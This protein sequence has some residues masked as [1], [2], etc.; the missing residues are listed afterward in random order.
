MSK[1]IQTRLG[2]T[3][4]AARALLFALS[5]TLLSPHFTDAQTG[6]KA[7]EPSSTVAQDPHIT[8]RGV[9]LSTV[10]RTP[11]PGATVSLFPGGKKVLTDLQGRF[12]L[13]GVEPSEGATV[14]VK[15][16]GY[17]CSPMLQTSPAPVCYKNYEPQTGAMTLTLLPEAAIAGQV[18]TESGYPIE[19]INVFISVK[20]VKDGRY[21]W[22]P[23]DVVPGKTDSA[24]MFRIGNLEP[25]TYLVRTPASAIV[26]VPMGQNVGFEATWY[27]RASTQQDAEPIVLDAGKEVI[28]NLVVKQSLVLINIPFTWNR[29]GEVGTAEYGLSVKDGDSVSAGP[30]VITLFEKGHLFQAYVPYGHYTFSACLYPKGSVT[31]AAIGPGAGVPQGASHPQ[32]CGYEDFTVTEK[33]ISAPTLVLQQPISVPLRVQADLTRQQQRQGNKMIPNPLVAF[34]LSGGGNRFGKRVVWR[35]GT[36]DADMAFEGVGPGEYKLDMEGQQAYV[37]SAACGN[38]D[39]LHDSLIVGGGT[40]V[41]SIGVLLRNDFANV[42]VTLSPESRAKMAGAGLQR[43]GIFLVPLDY[44]SDRAAITSMGVNQQ[45]WKVQLKPG[46]YLAFASGQR[47]IAWYEPEVQR[48]LVAAGKVVTFTPGESE[49]LT[50]EI[51]D[52]GITMQ[53]P[54]IILP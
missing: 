44:V 41:C 29:P 54:S 51:N 19:G 34:T 38:M 30:R 20:R 42:T 45:F 18:I 15:K 40:P 5:M 31:E 16:A 43:T 12:E 11:I 7:T 39:L 25:G 50:L 33:T 9:V 47:D 32:L 35:Q 22:A 28:A 23:V 10:D 21:V 36:P 53:G 26:R 8:V 27:P 17:L 13:D 2:A 37:A 49:M 48:E 52:L 6:A 46:R 3:P 4:R 1:V 14:S 24:G